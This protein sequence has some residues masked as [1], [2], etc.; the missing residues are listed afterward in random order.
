MWGAGEEDEVMLKLPT[1]PT[2]ENG[3]ILPTVLFPPYV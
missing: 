1:V 3:V 2:S